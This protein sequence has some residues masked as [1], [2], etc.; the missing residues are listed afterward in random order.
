MSLRGVVATA[1]LLLGGAAPVMAGHTLSH[2]PSYYPDEI[3]I[4]TLD[5][6]AAAK[7]LA[8]ETL[9]AY[10]GAPPAFA[11][12]VPAH[13]RPLESLKSFLVLDLDPAM[14]A[15][16]TSDRRCA[17]GN[18]L[19]FALGRQGAPGFAFHPYPVTPYHPDFV[20]HADR[21][22]A[23][24]T[25]TR[26]ANAQPPDA[27]VSAG[28]G[29]GQAI[30]GGMLAGPGAPPGA[31]LVEVPLDTLADGAG[32]QLDGWLGPPWAKLGWFQAY[33]LLAAFLDARERGAAERLYRR[34]VRGEAADLAEE[35]E[36]ERRLVAT[37]TRGCRRF[38]VGYALR[39]EYINEA[40]S[41]GIENVAYDAHAGLGA[42]V[43]VRT[44]KLKDF[45][46][47]GR[48][49]LGHNG[50]PD[51]AWN[52]VAGFTDADGRLVWSAL[53]DPALFPIPYNAG[54]APNRAQFTVAAAHGQSGGIRIPAGV[55]LPEPG[56]GRLQ[57][58]AARSFASA[59][60]TYE[61]VG[62]PY[63]DG[64]AMDMADA[65]YP[66]IF[67]YRWGAAKAPDD[68]PREPAL[69]TA[70]GAMRERLVGIQPVRMRRELQ[71][72]AEN[73]DIEHRT[74]M[75]EV[76]VRD[77]PGVDNQ[78]AAM[79]PPW[80]AVPWHL[81]ALMEA[82]VERDHAAF[83]RDE[84]QRRGAPWLDL[85]RDAALR[86]KLLDLCAEFERTR[87]R[88]AGLESFVTAEDATKRWKALREFALDQG[89][90]LVTNGP[91]R[92]KSWT[93]N[94]VVLAAVREASYPLGFGMFDHMANPPR[95]VIRDVAREPGAIAVG[96]DA[97]L[98]VKVI[99]SLEIRREPLTRSTALG[100][101]GVQVASRYLLLGADGTVAA[102]GR[103]EWGADHRFRIALP[104]G[105]SQGRHVAVFAVYLDGS[106]VLPAV[107]VFGFE[108]G[109]G[110]R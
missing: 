40:P 78:L 109:G 42:P 105:L 36:L 65:V 10:V 81:L 95:A 74:V 56:T 94:S 27:K 75:V 2:Y 9:H 13:V 38:V 51:A 64:T 82:A 4:D 11:G 60:I 46:W 34:I 6:A 12:P 14:P 19:A 53:G 30:A 39:R 88:P 17:V 106:A 103:M 43:F 79:A 33:K 76:F 54:W 69:A 16:A 7:G 47:N 107:G 22:E 71:N 23:A 100:T 86:A 84:A 93:G 28:P 91:Y 66:F 98:T 104:A 63:L 8:D 35:A 96:A 37:L 110:N 1:A 72:I 83:S 99:R 62:S 25:A 49:Q 92:L 18:A 73:L 48:L 70:L 55:V 58:I 50:R 89:H 21:A 59:K 67:A 57:P 32:V 3:V 45:P 5:P 102:A 41:A 52:P 97:E 68:R 87:F 20:H 90:F 24:T 29:L 80:T 108:A 85:V 26:A 61:V 31:T 77:T 15:Y 44:A 101:R